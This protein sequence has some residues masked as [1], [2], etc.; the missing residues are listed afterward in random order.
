MAGT[1]HLYAERIALLRKDILKLTQHYKSLQDVTNPKTLTPHRA[2]DRVP[3][4]DK[5]KETYIRLNELGESLEE[6]AIP[7]KIFEYLNFP[8]NHILEGTSKYREIVDLSSKKSAHHKEDS[9]I[10]EE[11]RVTTS[12]K[13]A[14]KV[15][16]VNTVMQES[17][18]T[19]HSAVVTAN[20]QLYAEKEFKQMSKTLLQIAASRAERAENLRVL[21]KK[22]LGYISKVPYSSVA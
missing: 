10:V 19:L 15:T 2:L 8:S 17:T 1:A 18:A 9:S 20:K 14:S 11:N 13:H 22:L 6:K 4:M 21:H 3:K 7:D 12:T 16:D 5:L